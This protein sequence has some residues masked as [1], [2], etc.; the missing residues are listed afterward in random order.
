[1]TKVTITLNK[2]TCGWSLRLCVPVA[3]SPPLCDHDWQ[4]S[5]NYN[6][7]CIPLSQFSFVS[8]QSASDKQSQWESWQELQ[9]VIVWHPHN[10]V[11]ELSV[12]IAIFMP[13]LPGE[14]FMFL[15]VSL[16][17]Y[18]TGL[19]NTSFHKKFHTTLAGSK[20]LAL[21]YVSFLPSTDF[22]Y[23]LQFKTT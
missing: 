15:L 7:C 18:T 11:I 14:C 20:K 1:M 3:A 2:E 10:W 4:L 16:S 19:C 12:P 23:C 5:H 6:G 9:I 17:S 8:F 13:G 21:V 22:A